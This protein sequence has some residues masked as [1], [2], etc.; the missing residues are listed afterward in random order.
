MLALLIV[1][2]GTMVALFQKGGESARQNQVAKQ[3]AETPENPAEK[4]EKVQPDAGKQAQ[5]RTSTD[6]RKTTDT[7]EKK[8][9]EE[10]RASVEAELEDKYATAEEMAQASAG[11]VIAEN[12]SE[13]DRL[14]LQW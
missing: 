9:Q 3:E 7:K 11:D 2:A 14:S 4:P 8:V 1:S 13:A 5:I 12:F 6:N 10:A